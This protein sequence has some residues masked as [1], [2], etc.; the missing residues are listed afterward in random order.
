M[1]LLTLN[2]LINDLENIINNYKKDSDAV[3]FAD[4]CVFGDCLLSYDDKE[5]I[6]NWFY[7][8]ASQN[9]SSD[10]KIIKLFLKT[11]IK[12]YVY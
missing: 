11:F 3:S 10:K 2:T 9:F 12:K 6:Q 4:V 1:K 5:L 8:L 7:E